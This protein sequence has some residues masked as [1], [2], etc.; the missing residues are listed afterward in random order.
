MKPSDVMPTNRRRDGLRQAAE[1]KAH[2][3]H[4]DDAKAESDEKLVLVWARIKM[5]DDQPLHQHPNEHHKERTRDNRQDKR[6]GIGIGNP[7]GV[8][9]QHEHRAVGEVKHAERAIDDRQAGR[10]QREK[11][12]EHQS[13]ETLRYESCPVDHA[14]ARRLNADS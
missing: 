6:P 7:A 11:R 9:A 8:A 3:L 10:N 13:I 12:A 5:A 1:E 4:E 2:D 14:S